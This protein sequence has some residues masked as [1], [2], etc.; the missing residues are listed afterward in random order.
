MEMII[1]VIFG[2]VLS[3]LCG[4]GVVYG[5]EFASLVRRYETQAH[6]E[7]EEPL[8]TQ[9]EDLLNYDGRAKE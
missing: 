2:C 1:A 8:K 5:R 3:F 6:Q 9:W 7:E 4:A